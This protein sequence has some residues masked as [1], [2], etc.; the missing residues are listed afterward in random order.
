MNQRTLLCVYQV[1]APMNRELVSQVQS[2]FNHVRVVHH[3]FRPLAR[4][5]AYPLFQA[6]SSTPEFN[7]YLLWPTP[8][9]PQEVQ[10]QVDKLIREQTMERAAPFSLVD[11]DTGYWKGMC[12]FRPYLDGVEISTYL[13]P[14][15]WARG[16]IV[17]TGSCMFQALLEQFPD[18]P[19]YVRV[20]LGNRPM[21]KICRVHK[22]QELE[23]DVGSHPVE[24]QVPLRVFRLDRTWPGF[25][26]TGVIPY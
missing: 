9:D 12:V 18:S 21:L 13:H 20:R 4:A 14:N 11:R 3:M 2:L 24:G 15:E 8:K 1:I 22:L 6:A 7:R 10:I 16:T 23:Q 5:D 25:G 26:F 19:V 17:A